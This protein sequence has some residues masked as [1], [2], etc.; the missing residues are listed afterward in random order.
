MK[1]FL[2]LYVKK[3]KSQEIVR[4]YRIFGWQL[5]KASENN[6]YEDLVDLTFSRPHNIPNKDELQLVQ[7]YMEE[8]VNEIAKE[9]HHKHSK[10]IALGLSCGVLGLVLIALGLLFCFNILPL[11]LVA[12]ILFS[13]FGCAL[14]ILGGIFIPML[15]RRE[16]KMFE[17]S[18]SIKLRELEEICEHARSLSGGANG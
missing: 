4:R 6:L 16:R 18:H 1:D 11:G 9:E 12:G 17:K 3:E 15:V 10:S 7:V 13:S 14:W 5:E 2:D 8:K